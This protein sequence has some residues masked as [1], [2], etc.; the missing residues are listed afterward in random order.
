MWVR[1]LPGKCGIKSRKFQ[2]THPCGCDQ[3]CFENCYNP[4]PFQFTHPCGCDP[5][6]LSR[7]FR[8]PG[9][10]SRT[11]VGATNVIRG[12]GRALTVSIHAPVWVRLMAEVAENLVTVFQFTHPCGCDNKYGR[13][14]PL[15][16]NVTA[17]MV[18]IDRKM[19]NSPLNAT[20]LHP[21]C[22]LVAPPL[23]TA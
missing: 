21:H 19:A 14:L 6:A 17:N 12:N 3:Q 16:C 23:K 8:L 2:F 22:N 13:T 1:L 9:F 15:L 10:N 20:P 5:G 11:R 7:R 4:A 18:K